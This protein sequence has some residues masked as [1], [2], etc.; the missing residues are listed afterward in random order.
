MI[1]SIALIAAI[2]LTAVATPAMA[3]TGDD[4][5]QIRIDVADLDLATAH[6]RQR[7]ATRIR[8]TV[9][10]LCSADG[11]SVLD[12]MRAQECRTAALA[13]VT[14]QVDRAIALAQRNQRL[15]ARDV[16]AIR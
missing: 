7:L 16:P 14:P 8:T 13:A 9:N 11:R 10:S 6:D 2:S 4:R 5:P 12:Q 3:Q 1:R 15:A